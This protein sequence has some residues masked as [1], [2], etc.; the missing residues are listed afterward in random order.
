MNLMKNPK[1]NAAIILAITMFYSLV[2]IL[3][4]GHLEFGRILG[5]ANT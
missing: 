3:T 1:I 4:S 5:H 2:F